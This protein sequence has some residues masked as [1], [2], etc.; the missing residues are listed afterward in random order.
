MPRPDLQQMAADTLASIRGYTE[1]A[2]APVAG[3][4]DSLERS[5][6]VLPTKDFV[7]AAVN[8]SRAALTLDIVAAMA[9]AGGGAL[10]VEDVTPL[11]K[12]LV[13]M[14]PVPKDGEPGADGRDGQ[15]GSSVEPAEVQ[16]MVE[17]AVARAAQAL[18]PPE[19][20]DDVK[21]FADAITQRF[22]AAAIA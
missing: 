15:D 17:T 14:L 3:R 20:P 2:V 9:R 18:I 7:S 10:T 4:V 22:M 16:A 6:A 13:A 21:A 12:E 8:E 1:R 19:Q 5:V 11:V